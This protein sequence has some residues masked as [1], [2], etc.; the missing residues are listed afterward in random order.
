MGYNINYANRGQNLENMIETSNQQYSF[1]QRALIQKIP[2]P[3]KV[4]NINSRTGKIT[5]GFYKKKSTVDYIGVYNGVSIA[6]DA[7]ETSI[8]TRFDLSNVKQHQHKYLKQWNDNGGIGFLIIYFNKLDELYYLPFQLLDDYW[9]GMLQGGRKSIPYQEIAQKEF[10]IGSKGLVL[11]DY[12]SIVD[13][14]IADK[15]N[16]NS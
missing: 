15:D 7:K 9:Q 8:K 13:K 10:L 11:V 2:T 6:F 5:N 12:L 4:L 1:Q 16:Y 3:V 14:I